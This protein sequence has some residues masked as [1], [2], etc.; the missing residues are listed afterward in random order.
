MRRREFLKAGI[1]AVGAAALG[2]GFW[3]RLY[4]APTT[5]GPSPYGPLLAAD[6][7]GL[8]LPA[9]FTS[10]VIAR[11]ALPVPGTLYPWPIFPDGAHCFPTGDG[12]WNL[13]VNSETPTS[14]GIVP[15]QVQRFGGASRIRFDA[16][17]KIVGANGVLKNTR[18]NC[19]GGPTPWGTW[20]SCEEFDDSIRGGPTSQ[21]G[22][23]WECDPNGV[24]PAK[25]RDALGA[26]KHEAA[27]VDPATNRVYLTEDVG[28]G[29]FYRFTPAAFTGTPNDLN[30]GTLAAAQLVGPAAGPWNVVWLPVP[31]PLALT[32]STRYQA[33]ASTPFRGGEGC[34]H[35]DGIVYITT[36]GDNRV[37]RYFIATQTM[38]LLYDA[39][40]PANQP[41]P[42][43]TGVD[44][45]I[46]ARSGDVLVAE[47]GGNM[48]IAIITPDNDVAP[49][50]RATGPQHGFDSPSPVPTRSE[51]TGLAFSPDG[52]RLYFNS[53]RG[54]VL[55]ITYEVRGPFRASA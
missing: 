21:A 53:Q 48:E 54:F 16:S 51:I 39:N 35:D 3:E 42:V 20:L 22:K 44:N 32:T 24:L 43:L 11:S 30:A 2:P 28:D 45:V 37:W 47:D 50:L 7:Q 41:D 38:D 33:P 27:A 23:V 36:K 46:V 26:F 12:G 19:A 52:S 18:T 55:G 8:M 1:A 15:D 4:A 34:F 6:K 17:G 9:G 14:D 5:P 31:D 49:L 10:R 40:D 25:R 29:R 13:V